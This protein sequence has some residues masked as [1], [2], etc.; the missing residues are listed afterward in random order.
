MPYNLTNNTINFVTPIINYKNKMNDLL[1]NGTEIKQRIISEINNSNQCLY[2]AMAYFTDREIAMA[3][4]QAYNRN[5]SI[6][7]ILSSNAQNETV[8]LMLKGAGIKV[9]AFDTGDARG[10]MHHKF[11]LIDNSITIN[12]SYNYSLNASTNNVENIQI[13]KDITIYSKFLDEFERL[14]YNIDNNISVNAISS[15]NQPDS[16]KQINQ[17]LNIIESF[18]QQLQNL[19]F[20]ATEIDTE[21]YKSDGYSDAKESQGNIDIFRTK[22][23]VIRK[24][25]RTYATDE[26]LGSK[27]NILKSNIS[28]TYDGFRSNLDLE[29]QEKLEHEKRRFE[30]DKKLILDKISNTQKEVS[31]LE[32]GNDN[33][34]EIGLILI[35][36]DIEKNKS[37][38]KSLEKSII[39]TPFWRLG[40]VLVTLLLAVFSFYLSIFFSSAMYKVFF[41]GNIIRSN[42]EDG[43]TP[44]L[45]QIVD[46]NA[47]IKI[48]E[49]QGFLF[50]SIATI[51]FIFPV[52]LSNLNLFGKKNR[53]LNNVLFW[54]G[55]LVFDIVVAAVVAYNTNEIKSLLKGEVVDIKLTDI[56]GHGEFWLMFIFGMVPLIITHYAIDYIADAYRNSQPYIVDA[57]KNRKIIFLEQELIDLN[58]KKES[59]IKNINEKNMNIEEYK[60]FIGE[61]EIQTNNT[62]MQIEN[63]YI[64]L[65]NKIQFIFNDYNTRI[66]S[67]IIF[68]DVI[69]DSIVS[70]YKSGFIEFLPEY[71]SSEEVTFRVKE[72]ESTKLIEN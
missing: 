24:K 43:I 25:T 9:H 10:I 37:E 46:A 51:F 2:L 44:D 4:I 38:S 3:I 32:D 15:I 59:I 57:E 53:K 22:F 20:S 17:P 28:S 7:I 71:Y 12:G 18:L 16:V 52:L 23:N 11:L 42:L 19:V 65:Q 67:G 26:G 41:E 36:K 33:I 13:S 48:F 62:Q 1:T 31:K 54:V 69:F 60:S 47:I 66:N 21:Q 64:E 27:K 49:D 29:K 61:M 55:I 39:L 72:I 34:G 63:K 8:K 58:S 30:L 6:D 14:K 50:A 35:N 5:V 40:T 68:T 45:P 56:I 70:A